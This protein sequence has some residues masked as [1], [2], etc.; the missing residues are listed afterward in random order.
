MSAK[1]QKQT[2]KQG[3]AAQ[4]DVESMLSHILLA[5]FPATATWRQMCKHTGRDDEGVEQTINSPAFRARLG[6]SFRARV[7]V[8]SAAIVESLLKAA[9]KE[10]GWAWKVLLEITGIR[11]QLDELLSAGQPNDEGSFI[12]SEF[13]RD[14]LGKLRQLGSGEP[15]PQ[16]RMRSTTFVE[17]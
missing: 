12:S 16:A 2:R 5:G 4:R 8:E 14:L 17:E 3:P 13:E 9:R 1:K 10:Q 6:A 11:D 15:G 7:Y